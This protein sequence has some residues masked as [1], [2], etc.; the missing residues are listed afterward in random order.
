MTPRHLIVWQPRM[1][2]Q[3]LRSYVMR[4]LIA[5]IFKVKSVRK[6]TPNDPGSDR[7]SLMTRSRTFVSE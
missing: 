5:W 3:I 2:H 6:Q 1:A 7:K 4:L